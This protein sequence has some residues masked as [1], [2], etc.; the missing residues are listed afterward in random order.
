MPEKMIR[1]PEGHFFDPG[2]HN[3]CPWCALPADSGPEQKTRPVG[4]GAP[5]PLPGAG[6]AA[7][8][9]PLP[10]AAPA[11]APMPPPSNAGKTMRVGGME[12]KQGIEPV[13]GWLVC[14]S[15]P[16]RGRDFRLHAEKNYIGRSPA[17]DV[18]ILNDNSVSRDKHGI[19]VYDPRKR[20]F[21]AL[22]GEASGLVYLN[23]EVIYTPTQ[24]NAEDVL[25]LG[26]TK[27]LLVPFC[28]EKYGWDEAGA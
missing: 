1:G 7:G 8:P 12:T 19:V 25:E 16:D 6:P 13:V 26:Q 23:G 14:T 3:A 11:P 17:M 21:W 22:P 10:G 27:L 28:S 18:V 5:P 2:K 9:P 20:N 4:M 15:G 24:M